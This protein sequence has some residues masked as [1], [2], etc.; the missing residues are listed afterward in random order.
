[1][2]CPL[3]PRPLLYLA[4]QPGKIGLT[5]LVPFLS[6]LALE[7]LVLRDE[8]LLLLLQVVDLGVELPPL[9]LEQFLAAQQLGLDV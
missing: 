3:I 4:L 7:V 9:L 5:E 1:M 6:V 2:L 8:F